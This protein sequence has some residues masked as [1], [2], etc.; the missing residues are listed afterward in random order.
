MILA[1]REVPGRA[2]TINYPSSCTTPENTVI[3][4]EMKQ[5]IDERIQAIVVISPPVPETFAD[6][7]SI[8]CDI[9]VPSLFITGTCDDGIVGSTRARDRR[10]PFDHVGG[11]AWMI[12][13]QGTDHMVYSGHILPGHETSD[14]YYQS[15]IARATKVFWD[16]WLKQTPT[17]VDCS[18][19]E[20]FAAIVANRACVE[21]KSGERTESAVA[22]P[23][24]PTLAQ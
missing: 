10:I 16:T 2:Y 14:R 7:D 15:L 6:H 4:D 18:L 12:T 9:A 8:Y 5:I 19:G 17:A 11:D 22:E 24:T 20:Q 21:K 23:N 1:G 13:F 3:Q